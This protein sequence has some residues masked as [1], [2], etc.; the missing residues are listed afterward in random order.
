M[1]VG[2]FSELRKREKVNG[3]VHKRK[4]KEGK[5]AK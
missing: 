2:P 1:H 5:S 3:N 4:T